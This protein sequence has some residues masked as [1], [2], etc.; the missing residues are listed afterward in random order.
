M[1]IKQL[2]GLGSGVAL[3]LTLASTAAADN[4]TA[5]TARTISINSIAQ[6]T[7]DNV[8]TQVWYRVRLFANRSY[9]I[10]AWP[11]D[12]EQG[13]D[14][15]VMGLN[16]FSDDPGT[17]A[18][19]P[20]PTTTSGDLEGSPNN[21]GDAL[22]VTTLFQPTTTGVYKIKVSRVSGGAVTASINVMVR[23]TTLFSPWLSKAAGF[24]GFI[25]IHNNTSA[26]ISVT[27][28][29]F[30]ATGTLQGAGLTF[31]LPSN[32]TVFKTGADIGVPVN[33]AAG[34]V[35]THNAAF[36]A[37]AGNITTLNGANGLSFD[38]PFTSRDGA[39]MGFPVR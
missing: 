37:I 36:G 8:R 28:K 24:E 5:V 10:S 6:N 12:H 15:P 3:C 20:A 21:N 2:A 30:D 29:G 23:E 27:L 16:L 25:E 26:A 9:Q 4:V 39:L 35:L 14:A 33:V 32:A 1:T 22:P 34:V 11:V 13:V 19:V 7:L 18:A 17:V 31:S 38:S